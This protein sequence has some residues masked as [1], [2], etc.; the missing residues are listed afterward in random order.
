[1]SSDQRA[2]VAC[3]LTAFALPTISRCGRGSPSCQP[4]F[5]GINSKI[6]VKQPLG[7]LARGLLTYGGNEGCVEGVVREAEQHTGLPHARI[8]DQE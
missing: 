2:L 7:S 8:S 5:N 6:Q 3:W 4:A 1:M